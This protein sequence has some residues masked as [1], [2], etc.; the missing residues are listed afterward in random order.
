M[1]VEEEASDDGSEPEERSEIEDPLQKME[2]EIARLEKELQYSAAEIANI[3]QRSSR[4]KSDAIRFGASSLSRKIL[5][6]IGNLEK[7]VSTFEESSSE[8]FL[9]G[10]RMA[11]EGIWTALQSEGVS[12]VDA[13]GGTFDPTCM[14]AIATVAA[15]DGIDPGQVVEVVEEGY[16]LH[17]RVLRA[18][19]VIVAEA[20]V[21]EPSD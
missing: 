4:D 5:P 2:L 9:D 14:E 6:L 3:R 16:M 21:D 12:R 7:A 13:V 15:P 20:R 10:T 8:A 19:R 11:L 1:D 17:Y 18:A